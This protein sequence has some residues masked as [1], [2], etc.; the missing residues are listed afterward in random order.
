MLAM[1]RL[2]ADQAL[3][4][5]LGAAARTWWHEHATIA[6]AVTAWRR[7]LDEPGLPPRPPLAGADGSEHARE[8]LAEFGVK[9]DFL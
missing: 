5:S 9:V 4:D 2:T 3:R 7:I 6:H 8:V 1:K